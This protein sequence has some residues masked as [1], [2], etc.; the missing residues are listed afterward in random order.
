LDVVYP[1]ARL[2]AAAGRIHVH[3]Q[4]R[5]AGGK[6]MTPVDH[7][8][9]FIAEV[10][11]DADLAPL[12]DDIERALQAVDLEGDW[13]DHAAAFFA[14]IEWILKQ[15]ATVRE[16]LEVLLKLTQLKGFVHIPDMGK[17]FSETLQQRSN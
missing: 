14:A 11:A 16:R 9:K 2:A 3:Y 8:A 4:R 15:P 17:F 1:A 13:N 12:A 7:I 5:E 10:R 6:R